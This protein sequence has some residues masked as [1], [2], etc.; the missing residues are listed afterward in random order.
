MEELIFMIE[1]VNTTLWTV[2]WNTH[3]SQEMLLVDETY[4]LTNS[5]IDPTQLV[6]PFGFSFQNALIY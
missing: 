1:S 3:A 2:N 5:V 4:P 6:S